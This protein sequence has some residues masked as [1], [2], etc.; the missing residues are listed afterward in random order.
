MFFD[1]I[2]QFSAFTLML[3][4]VWP[5]G[6]G[7]EP[8]PALQLHLVRGTWFAIQGCHRK[9][10]GAARWHGRQPGSGAGLRCAAQRP[11]T[12]GCKQLNTL[13]ITTFVGARLNY[14]VSVC[15]RTCEGSSLE[16]SVVRWCCISS[17]EQNKCEQWALSIKSD[18][19]VCI[20]AASMSDCVEKIKV[21]YN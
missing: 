9:A 15:V 10:S 18:P 7:E 13:F 19:L 1:Q 17:A 16:D 3:D 14:C 11:R 20:K 2:S 6:K 12:W 4:F 5:T 8:L 21:I